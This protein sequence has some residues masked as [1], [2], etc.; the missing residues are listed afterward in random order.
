MVTDVH[1]FDATFGVVGT[2]D[3]G[4]GGDFDFCF[5]CSFFTSQNM[6]LS[7]VSDEKQENMRNTLQNRHPP[8]PQNVRSRPRATRKPQTRR[9]Q[10]IQIKRVASNKRTHSQFIYPTLLHN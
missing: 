5:S 6:V 8:N 2:G 9:Q 7:L 1:F 4:D 10:R 3:N